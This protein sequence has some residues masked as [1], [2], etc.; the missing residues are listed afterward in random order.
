MKFEFSICDEGELLKAKLNK[1]ADLYTLISPKFDENSSKDH[2]V[3]QDKT[4]KVLGKK[5]ISNSMF[6]PKTTISPL[7]P[8]SPK[9]FLV[10]SFLFRRVRN[11]YVIHE[12]TAFQ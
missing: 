3:N 11:M 8:T 2:W 12:R 4:Q 7:K 6:Y 1:Y 5:I 10:L 9:Q